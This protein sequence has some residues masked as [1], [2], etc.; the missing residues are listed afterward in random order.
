MITEIEKDKSTKP[1]LL[2]T[3]ASPM[4]RSVKIFQKQ[5]LNITPVPVDYQ[6]ANSLQWTEFDLVD[7][8][9]NWN[10]LIHEIIGLFA[11]WITG[12]I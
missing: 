6:T 7:G 10:K 8:A 12:K 4:Y 11:Y 5:G 2:I 1:W 9:Q 3:S